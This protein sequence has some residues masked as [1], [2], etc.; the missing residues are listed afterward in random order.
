MTA[1]RA[2]ESSA[3][4]PGVCQVPPRA[5]QLSSSGSSR[6]TAL[7]NLASGVFSASNS[8]HSARTAALWSAGSSANSS[9]AAAVSRS[10]W[11]AAIATS[12]SGVSPA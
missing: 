1:L 6:S 9:S 2:R 4:T 11:S 7:A 10:C 3:V 8:S 12:Y 5:I